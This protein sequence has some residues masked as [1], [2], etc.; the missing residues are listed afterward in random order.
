MENIERHDGAN[1]G[2]QDRLELGVA[3][4][5]FDWGAVEDAAG[6]LMESLPAAKLT[7]AQAEIVLGFLSKAIERERVLK[8][9]RMLVEVI[10]KLI[11]SANLRLDIYS[12][13]LVT[14]ISE[15]LGYGSQDDVARLM[16]VSRSNVS[17]CARRW[18]AILPFKSLKFTRNDENRKHCSDA[19][20][21]N[22]WRNRSIDDLAG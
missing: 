7:R 13:A 22:H 19:Q 1:P 18:A 20:A 2:L 6:V 3:H 10:D 5:D 15:G 14:G 8:E 12:M 9:S 4:E 16:K 11:N 21:K 17:K